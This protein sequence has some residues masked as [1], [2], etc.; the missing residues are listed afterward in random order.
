MVARH[1][2]DLIGEL[3]VY[4]TVDHDENTAE[5]VD[6][7]DVVASVRASLAETFTKSAAS[8]E[9]ADLPTIRGNRIRREPLLQNLIENAIKY[10]GSNLPRVRLD[11]SREGSMWTVNCRDN[12]MGVPVEEREKI[13]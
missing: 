5:P 10:R 7:N 2:I 3:L 11:A 6:L 8:I 13:F 9:S 1:A 12:R 4:A